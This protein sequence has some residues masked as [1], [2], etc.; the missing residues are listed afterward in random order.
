MIT[1][2]IVVLS[3]VFAYWI[4]GRIKIDSQSEVSN[5]LN[6]VL[7][8]SHQAV[9]TWLKE[10]QA[11]ALVTVNTPQ[12]L[13]FSKELLALQR[14]RDALITSLTQAKLRNLLTPLLKSKGYQG[15]YIIAP[16]NI[17]ISSS[18]AY[19]IGLNNPPVKQDD[20]LK[21]VWAGN[22]AVSLP[23]KSDVLLPDK[24]GRLKQ[25]LPTM[26]VGAPIKDENGKV[27]AV[28][29]YR[30]NPT[31][32]FISILQEG[33]IGQTGET[34]AFDAKGRLISNSRF[35]ERLQQLGL[36]SPGER[37]ILNV[38][39]RELAVAENGIK[40]NRD[41][42]KQQPLTRMAASA[43]KGNSSSDL[44]GYRNY[45]GKL[46][47]GAWLWDNELGFG[48]A[49]EQDKKE[50]YQSLRTTQ[51]VMIAMTVLIILLLLGGVIILIL[52]EQRQSAE[53]KLQK[54][55]LDLEDKIRERT[56]DLTLANKELI[57]EVFDR[58]RAEDSLR[59]TQARFEYLLFA[60]PAVIYTAEASGTFG[61]TFISENIRRQLGYE[62]E[63]FTS[64]PSFWATHIHPEDRERIF[65]ELPSLFEKGEHVHQYR[66]M[67]KDGSYRCMHDELK[68]LCDNDGNPLEI[69]GNWLDITESK[70]AEQSLRESE[71]RFKEIFE[72]SSLG[73]A[74]L[75]LSGHPI[76]TNTALQKMLGYT[77]DELSN[78]LFTEFTHPEDV[79][80]DTD[81][82][83]DLVNGIC[84][85]YS[86]EKRYSHK[87]GTLVWANLNVS[88]VRD[89]NGELRMI[90]G[91]VED[92]SVR[93]KVEEQTHFL[94]QQN[95]NLTQRMFQV[96]EQERQHLARELHDEFGQW[97]T[98]IQLDSQN[99]V[100]LIGN[101][102]E[103]V[104]ASINSIRLS[105][106]KIQKGIRSMIHSLRPALIDELGLQDS[107][108]EL[109]S[110]WSNSNPNIDCQLKLTGE[111]DTLGE[112]LS[113]T[114]YRLVQE[115]LTNVAKHASATQVKVE[116]QRKF[117]DTEQKDSLSLT[118]DDDGVG[119]NSVTHSHGF[120]LP[121][122]RERVLAEGGTFTINQHNSKGVSIEVWFYLQSQNEQ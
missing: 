16:D 69:V 70:R 112:N 121:G 15:Y 22:T 80:I 50:A 33:R 45:S 54:A 86:M 10:L 82:Y 73:M 28:F 78:M 8:A 85:H 84:N 1:F 31:V 41:K 42:I 92:I 4:Y 59:V 35:D 66:F 110:M 17:S 106:D 76:I 47:I 7:R 111:L 37:G 88:A 34:Y 6:T 12:V 23:E 5:S 72:R 71:A 29:A 32:D 2:F 68:L 24:D 11:T 61:A 113:I 91:I 21:K 100:N 53:R 40:I 63:E 116:L 67:H 44:E 60:S 103:K 52:Y 51:F 27:L 97:L 77:A 49:T 81:L 19:S 94:L 56:D 117:A 14:E 119:M 99:I 107:L 89:E 13:E 75:D 18:Q 9:R 64:D 109:I 55:H 87:N 96:Q 62:P 3:C 114:M 38:D 93:K 102:S 25:G 95:R 101:Q 122:M 79:E 36:I 105:A 39:I 43:T 57:V 30:I 120:G 115:G 90:I 118:I 48:L 104:D 26:F 65:A 108:R 20:F 98:A 83:Q 58:K 74:L 46:V